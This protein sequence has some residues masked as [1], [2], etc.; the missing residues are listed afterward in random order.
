MDNVP[1]LHKDRL[2]GFFD[3]LGFSS[4]LEHQTVEVVHQT[5]GAFID[6]A[7]NKDFVSDEINALNEAR[8]TSNFEATQFAFDTLVLVSSDPAQAHADAN[9]LF[10][11]IQ[12]MK[13]SMQTGLALRGAIGRGDVL[14]D[15]KHGILLSKE[16]PRLARLEKEQEWMGCC[17]TDEAMERLQEP[18]FGKSFG[19]NPHFPVVP[20]KVPMKSLKCGQP[21]YAINWMATT[22]DSDWALSIERLIP[23]KKIPTQEFAEAILHS[24]GF[25]QRIEPPVFPVHEFRYMASRLKVNFLF[26]NEKGEPVDPIEPLQISISD[27]DGNVRMIEFRSK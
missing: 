5:L 22:P 17:L 26:L 10:A 25:R 4:L 3:V 24:P 14:I 16:F 11:C 8:R 2:L 15:A 12:I 13:T 7:K 21:K 9:F 18:L 23:E 27:S 1:T 20:W 6:Q 19:F